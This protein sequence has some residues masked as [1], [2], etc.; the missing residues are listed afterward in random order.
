MLRLY[1]QQ[2]TADFKR[3]HRRAR[4]IAASLPADQSE[5]VRSLMRQ[6]VRFW[7]EMAALRL[8]LSLAWTGLGSV[9]VSGLVNAVAGMQAEIT[10]L[11][12]PSAA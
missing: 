2:L 7:Y 4:V 8:S 5:L 3:L 9:D 10:R 1:L 11:S 12:A 6:Q